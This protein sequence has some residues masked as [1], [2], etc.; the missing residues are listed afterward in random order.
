[1]KIISHS[2]SQATTNACHGTFVKWGSRRRNFASGAQNSQT[3]HRTVWVVVNDAVDL[4]VKGAKP[5]V[6]GFIK[7]RAIVFDL[8]KKAPNH[9]AMLLDFIQS[10]RGG[11]EFVRMARPDEFGLLKHA[12]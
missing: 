2:T 8:I 9:K 11:Q 7:P 1:M 4:E 6:L 10:F 5:L 12:A 3:C